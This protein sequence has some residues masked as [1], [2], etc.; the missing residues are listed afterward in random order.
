MGGRFERKAG[1]AAFVAIHGLVSADVSATVSCSRLW[2]ADDYSI[3]QDCRLTH[4]VDAGGKPL[5]EL[6]DSGHA[7]RFQ[8]VGDALYWVG[9][10]AL[11][12][13]DLKS[14]TMRV[15]VPGRIHDFAVSPDAST[16]VT[17]D[18]KA[19]VW[20]DG[21]GREGGGAFK[22][23]GGDV[24][25]AIK[26]RHDLGLLG[27]SEDNR[28]FWLCEVTHGGTRIFRVS[29]SGVVESRVHGGAA[30]CGGEANAVR[31]SNRWRTFDPDRGLIVHHVTRRD[32][33]KELWLTDLSTGRRVYLGVAPPKPFKREP[34]FALASIH[35]DGSCA[36]LTDSSRWYVPNMEWL[37]WSQGLLP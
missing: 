29:E 17:Y 13:A 9:A 7:G 25:T 19:F 34:E 27:W 30:A 26:A 14:R 24:R 36:Y 28:T 5:M 6:G 21:E 32:F 8:A 37:A 2:T 12:R 3:K 23:R 11:H 10:G 31:G 4:V 22:W 15:V 20:R 35:P 18:G 33:S 16:M 1:T